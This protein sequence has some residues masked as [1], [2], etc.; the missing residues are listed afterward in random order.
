M[1]TSQSPK[2]KLFMK[3]V[4]DKLKST[5]GR[6]ISIEDIGSGDHIISVE[7]AKALADKL[8]NDTSLKVLCLN[9]TEISDEG[10]IA[11]VLMLE[12]NKK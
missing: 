5:E 6:S 4:E 7:E 3:K 8:A 12:K 11:L 9:G 2:V 1:G 10:V